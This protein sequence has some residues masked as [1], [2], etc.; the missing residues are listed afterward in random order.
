MRCIK[1]GNQTCIRKV[2]RAVADLICA[3]D[4]V[5][6]LQNIICS[7]S[8]HITL[9]FILRI[10]SNL[11]LYPNKI[12]LFTGHFPDRDI[13]VSIVAILFSYNFILIILIQICF[14]NFINDD[15]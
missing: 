1:A 10:I 4:V 12:L 15:S 3:D 2:N 14:C 11:L 9:I 6:V 7:L 13:T 8:I 5:D